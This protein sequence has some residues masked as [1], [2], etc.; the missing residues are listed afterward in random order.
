MAPNKGDVP[1][2]PD[3]EGVEDAAAPAAGAPFAPWP[4][5]VGLKG[6]RL[7]KPGPADGGPDWDIS[8]GIYIADRPGL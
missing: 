6:A 2:C 4:P 8:F 1:A 3:P 7:L 5:R